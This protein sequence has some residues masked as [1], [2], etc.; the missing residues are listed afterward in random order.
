ML[1]HTLANDRIFIDSLRLKCLCGPNAFGRSKPQPV[2]LSVSLGTSIALAAASDKVELSIDYS[3]LSKQLI[4]FE[5]RGF[6]SVVDLVNQVTELALGKEGVQDVR[7]RVDLRKALLRGKNL[8]WETIAWVENGRKG[9]WKCSL[10][11]VDVPV[12]IGIAE[13]LHERTQKQ[14]VAIDIEWHG[15]D[16]DSN[17]LETFPV[18]DLMDTVIKV[19]CFTSILMAECIRHFIRVCGVTSDHDRQHCDPPYISQCQRDSLQTQRLTVCQCG[20][21]QNHSLEPILRYRTRQ[22][23]IAL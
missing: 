13:N 15:H 17:G 18:R 10:E 4:A 20:R 9:E 16:G 19:G 1:P 8:K 23:P 11:G 14:L 5:D 3:A 21:R 2:E 12:I 6:T 7:V 22:R